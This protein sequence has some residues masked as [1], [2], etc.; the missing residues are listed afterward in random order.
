MYS[1]SLIFLPQQA[2]FALSV[3]MNLI[4]FI[5]FLFNYIYNIIFWLTICKPKNNLNV[6]LLSIN[7]VYILVLWKFGTKKVQPFRTAPLHCQSLL[8]FNIASTYFTTLS[9]SSPDISLSL[10]AL[11]ISSFPVP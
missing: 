11:S 10:Y 5:L 8:A 6:G 4:I 9:Y 7:Y 2:H 3:L 1:T